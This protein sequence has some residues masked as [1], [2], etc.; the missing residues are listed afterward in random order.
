M[1]DDVDCAKLCSAA[2]ID[3]LAESPSTER[4]YPRLLPL[5]ATAQ[6]YRWLARSEIGPRCCSF[7]CIGAGCSIY[8]PGKCTVAWFSCSNNTSIVL[9]PLTCKD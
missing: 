4:D 3:R 8:R 2:V 5:S 7:T 1:N 6:P 9:V